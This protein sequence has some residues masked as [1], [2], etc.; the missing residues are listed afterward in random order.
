MTT[1]FE[2]EWACRLVDRCVYPIN[3]ST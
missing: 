3:V 2:L 1:L